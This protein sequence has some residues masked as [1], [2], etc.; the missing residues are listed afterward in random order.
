MDLNKV[1]DS[2][3]FDLGALSVETTNELLGAINALPPDRKAMAMKKMWNK[4]V[5][6]AL[7]QNSRTEFLR[8]AAMLPADIQKGLLDKRLQMVDSEFYF[9]KSA[10]GFKTVKMITD[11]DNK[12]P[13]LGNVS[14]QKLE[15]DN[16]F[17]LSGVVL[18]AGIAPLKED[19]TFD[20]IPH[21]IR[22]GDFELKINGGK[23]I[24]P[25]AR[26]SNEAFDTGGRTDIRKGL[27]R[28]ENPKLVEAEQGLEFNLD[29]AVAPAANTWL[30]A[31]LIGSSVAP[32]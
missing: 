32:Y 11:S 9:V 13:G 5:P 28:L 12:A 22:N 7:K 16:H 15:K 31:I 10:G 25:A 21:E 24:T 14:K 19:V 17:L 8:K 30:K 18:L 29:F 3:D 26:V 4:R 27:F 6:V 23:A 2:E 20:V 1:L